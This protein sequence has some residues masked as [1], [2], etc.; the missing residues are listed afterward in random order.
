MIIK[1]ND[2]MWIGGGD[3][4]F[5]RCFMFS[6]CKALNP[7]NVRGYMQNNVGR[8]L[9]YDGFIVFLSLSHNYGVL[10]QVWYLIVSISDRALLSYF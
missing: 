1:T 7:L 10:G 8:G 6:I 9:Q 5:Q 3:E 2:I 4:R